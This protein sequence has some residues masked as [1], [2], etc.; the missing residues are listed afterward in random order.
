M[1]RRTRQ[2]FPQK[3]PVFFLFHKTGASFAPVFHRFIPTFLPPC[4]LFRPIL[5]L[6]NRTPEKE[7]S[8]IKHLCLLP[9]LLVLLLA[10]TACGAPA[11]PPAAE[12]PA[13]SEEPAPEASAS[14][15][16]TLEELCGADYRSYITETITMQMENRMDKAPDVRY[17]PVTE[18]APLSDYAAIDET[19]PFEVDGDGHIVIYFAAGTVTDEANGEQSFRIPRP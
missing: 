11:A 19:T 4:K 5:R 3:E 18:G 9:A 12:A 15:A 1:R 16:P 13:I 10:L 8:P 6:S 2:V 7:A 14:E 17:F